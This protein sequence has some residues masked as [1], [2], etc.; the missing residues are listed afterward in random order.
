MKLWEHQKQAIEFIQDKPYSFLYAGMSTGKTVIAL[1]VLHNIPGLRLILTPKAGM[2]VYH[3][4]ALKFGY[5]IPLLILDRGTSKTKAAQL[6][7]FTDGIVIVNYET[8]RLLPLERYNWQAVV[9][10]EAHKLQTHNSKTSIALTRKL[11]KVPTK[12]AMTGTPYHDG[13]EKL[14]SVF[15]W[16]NPIIPDNPRAYP[17]SEMFGRYQD[18][19]YRFCWTHELRPGVKIITGYRNIDQLSKIIAP[20]TLQIKTDDVIDLPP[21]IERTYKAPLTGEA[22][23][24][25][26]E[27]EKE[28]AAVIDETLG[29]TSHVL[30]RA[31]RLHQ[32]ATIGEYQSDDGKVYAL[33]GVEGRKKLLERVLDDLGHTLPAVIF[34][35]YKADVR[36]IEAM[37]KEPIAKLTGDIDNHEAWKRGEYRLLIVNMAAG[38]AA[39]RLERAAHIIFWSVGYSNSEYQQALARVRRAGQTS[40]TIFVTHI[41]SEDTIDETI[42]AT[43]DSKEKRKE[44]LDGML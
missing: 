5:N 27:I 28:G 42:Y 36:L 2:N 19:L 24:V 39:V 44:A 6:D 8:A 40:N 21:V 41:V 32:I 11:A 35:R 4:D 14:Y 7:S 26:Q 18:F 38:S 31:L 30:T 15:R 33:K 29:A 34:T 23:R 9:A 16:L 17:L 12:L 43:L 13:Y 3:D 10:D 20:Y 1:E 25:Y 37:V 22:K